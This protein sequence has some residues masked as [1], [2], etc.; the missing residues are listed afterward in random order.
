MKAKYLLP[1]FVIVA[2]GCSQKPA[3]KKEDDTLKVQTTPTT[4]KITNLTDTGEVIDMAP[5]P[6]DLG[7]VDD[8]G[9]P[10]P[11]APPSIDGSDSIPG[12]PPI[13]GNNG[14]LELPGLPEF[15]D[16]GQIK[17]PGLPPIPGEAGS[18]N[19]EQE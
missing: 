6:S 12:L 16:D 15:D 19:E 7:P 4:Q 9:V 10:M 1:I 14:E 5:M 18:E 17:L 8:D 13:P 2:V 3:A 11:P